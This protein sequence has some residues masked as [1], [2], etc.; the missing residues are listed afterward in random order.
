MANTSSVSVIIPVYNGERYLSEAIQSVLD[1]TLPPAEIIVIDDGSIDATSQIVADI[2][3]VSSVSIRYAYQENQGP[4][5]ARNTGII[6]SRGDIL[7]Y[8]DADDLWV[9]NRLSLQISIL[10]LNPH[11][12][13]VFGRT[14]CFF[15][16]DKDM[17]SPAISNDSDSSPPS[18]F[19]GVQSGLYRR[20]V[21]DTIGLFD[22]KLRYHE[23]IDWFRR[24]RSKG[25]VI[26]PHED[27]VL[28]HRRHRNNMTNDRLNLQTDL[29]R[30]LWRS[31][32]VQ[33]SQKKSLLAWLTTKCNKL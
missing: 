10:N 32:R 22:D 30:M 19:L 25:V 26:Y 13:V 3:T 20:S 33:P 27:V 14:Q 11:A 29:I 31:P 2:A 28:L 8:Q 17:P 24:A 9:Y 23:D 4:A 18:W 7:A 6:E 5:A 1:Q 21:F 12:L 15:S 16:D